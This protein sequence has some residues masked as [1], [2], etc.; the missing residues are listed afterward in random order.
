MKF[1]NIA[2]IFAVF[3]LSVYSCKENSAHSHR[4]IIIQP[5]ADFSPSLAENIYKQIKELSP[6]TILKQPIE[7]PKQA[8][9]SLRNRYRADTLIYYLGQLGSVDTVIIGLTSKDISTTKGNIVDWGIMGLGYCPGE[10]CIVS[11]FRL[12]KFNLSEQFYK[13]AIHE[14]GHTQG[15]R[16][17][18]NKTCFMRDAE[19]GNPLNEEKD[20]CRSCKSFLR[21]K[22]WT[23]VNF[24]PSAAP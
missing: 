11:T 12:S 3:F 1:K 2:I 21:K 4:V 18:S 16:H 9:Y 15:L 17:C 14:L 6:S 23:F 19:G 24:R 10:A 20:F 5:F 7:L 13:V 8:F 22:G